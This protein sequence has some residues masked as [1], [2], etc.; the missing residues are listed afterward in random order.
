MPERAA[1]ARADVESALGGAVEK[2]KADQDALLERTRREIAS[3]KDKAI[4]ET[5]EITD[6]VCDPN[7]EECSEGPGE[8]GGLKGQPLAP[9]ELREGILHPRLS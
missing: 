6:V 8:K 9:P 4:A 5:P 1:Q 3:E 7:T 2:I